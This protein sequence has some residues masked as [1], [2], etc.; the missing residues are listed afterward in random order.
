MSWQEVSTEQKTSVHHTGA[1]V[2]ADAECC[3]SA[4]VCVDV[5]ARAR[6]LLHGTHL[7]L[8]GV[9]RCARL[10]PHRPDPPQPPCG[11]PMD[12]H[13]QPPRVAFGHLDQDGC[14][15][16][17]GL[18]VDVVVAAISGDQLCSVM[19]AEREPVQHLKTQISL[20][21]GVPESDQV[22]LLNGRRLGAKRRLRSV[23]PTRSTVTLVVS[24]PSCNRCG[25]RDGLWGRRARLME[26]AHC[27][28][29]YYCS[30]ECQVADARAHLRCDLP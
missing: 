2:G 1:R 16:E 10:L 29:A 24:R 28:E 5:W 17:D 14:V 27:L 7:C 20:A 6:V 22:L 25:T 9:S 26:C 23:L 18:T 30:S 8:Q 11:A 19:L 4:I 15:E 12:C 21:C 3:T 13:G